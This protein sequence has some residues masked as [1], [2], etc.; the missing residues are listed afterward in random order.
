MARI[1]YIILIALV[2]IASPMPQGIDPGRIY[3]PDDLNELRAAIAYEEC[4]RTPGCNPNPQ[5][6]VRCKLGSGADAMVK[7]MV[8]VRTNMGCNPMAGQVLW[9]TTGQCVQL[10]TQ[11]PCPPGHWVKLSQ[12]KCKYFST[13]VRPG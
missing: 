1:V 8:D 13:C 6:T 3:T 9:P 5:S 12:I 2:T 10:L 11:G 4:L 7:D